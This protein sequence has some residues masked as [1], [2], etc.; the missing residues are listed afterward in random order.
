M[1]AMTALLRKL[2]TAGL[3][4][5]LLL[6][7]TVETGLFVSSA[8]A[9]DDGGEDGDGNGGEGGG[10]DGDH[11]GEGG[12]HD[13]ADDGRRDHDDDDTDDDDHEEAYARRQRGEIAGLS[14]VLQG[15]RRRYGGRILDVKLGKKGRQIYYRIKL[16]DRTGHVRK[17]TIRAVPG[18]RTNFNTRRRHGR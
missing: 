14:A 13:G 8:L 7:A 5:A 2:L 4:M 11:G 18:V 17:V 9:D 16:L 1:T 12:G 10:D 6:S 15:L 3:A